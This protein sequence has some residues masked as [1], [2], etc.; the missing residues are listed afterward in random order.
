MT[1]DQRDE[2]HSV[3]DDLRAEEDEQQAE[4]GHAS[5]RLLR[6]SLRLEQ[7]LER[8]DPEMTGISHPRP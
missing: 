3:L 5:N 7:L 1:D 2:I 8:S 6:A 4:R